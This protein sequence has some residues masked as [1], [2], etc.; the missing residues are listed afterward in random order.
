MRR[1]NI[2]RL[3]LSSSTYLVLSPWPVVY[4]THASL[5]VKRSEKIEICFAI[6]STTLLLTLCFQQDTAPLFSTHKYK[7]H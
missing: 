6:S 1:S 5:T 2:A 7:L 3:V 4:A